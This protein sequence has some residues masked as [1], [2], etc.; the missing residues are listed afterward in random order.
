MMLGVTAAVGLLFCSTFIAGNTAQAQEYASKERA[1]AAAGYYARSRAMLVAALD[2]FEQGRKYAR[3]DLLIDSEDWRLKLITLTEELNRVIDPKPLITR[4][5]VVFRA[6]PRM[7]AREHDRVPHTVDGAQDS[8]IY[9]EEQRMKEIQKQRARMYRPEAAEKGEDDLSAAKKA[10]GAARGK[11]KAGITAKGIEKKPNHLS[12]DIEDLKNS[13]EQAKEAD[14][15]LDIAT[16]ET[17]APSAAK[18]PVE[19]PVKSIV[20]NKAE[21]E[22]IDNLVRDRLKSMESVSDA[23]AGAKEPPKAAEPKAKDDK[24]KTGTPAAEDDFE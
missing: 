13:E 2:E 15:G 20:P 24:G 11:S 3:P 12:D 5:G 17:A 21:S 22:A 10:P 6:N 19:P 7:I 4:D 14:G 16:P 18:A 8:N 23:G 1:R 9:G